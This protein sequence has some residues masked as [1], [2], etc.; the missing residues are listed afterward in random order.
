MASCEPNSYNF[1]WKII[2]TERQT[3]LDQV[4]VSTTICLEMTTV[5]KQYVKETLCKALQ[6]GQ[7]K[8]GVWQCNSCETLFWHLILMDFV[9]FW[10]GD[11]S[12]LDETSVQKLK[13]SIK[14]KCQNRVSQELTHPFFS[15]HWLQSFVRP[16][17]DT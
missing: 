12:T 16:Y 9:H 13:K 17:S 1:I 3:K 15:S 10:T 7:Q 8:K 4:K 11:S 5:W 14:I 2:Y 6:S